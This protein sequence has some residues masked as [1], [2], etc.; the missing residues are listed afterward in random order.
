MKSKIITQSNFLVVLIFGLFAV[1]FYFFSFIGSDYSPYYGDEF[2]Y[3]KNAESFYQFSEFHGAFT[4]SGKGSKLLGFDPHGPAYPILYGSVAKLIGWHGPLIPIFN[5]GILIIALFCLFLQK[6]QSLELKYIQVILILGSPVTLF[7]SFSFLPELL[8]IAGAIFLFL[9]FKQYYRTQK[10]FDLILLTLL[11]LSLGMIRTIWFFALIALMISPKG[12]NWRVG[13]GL[14][15]LALSLSYFSQALF[16]EPVP[17]TF[18]ELSELVR[19]KNY[20]EA[21]EV[22][23]F[24]LKRN[25]YF[26][27]TYSEGKFYTI[28]KIWLLASIAF[29]WVFFRK[30]KL[31]Q[32]GLLIF[33]MTY[34]FNMF[35]YK[36]YSWV[37]LRM[38]TPILL[39]I[40]LSMIASSNHKFISK[41]LVVMGLSS[42]VLIIPLSKKLISYRI[43]SDLKNIPEST[44]EALLDLN[45]PLILI[46]KQA[47]Q[48]YS[49]DQLPISTR[50]KKTIRYILPFYEV[51]IEQPTHKITEEK[52][53]LKVSPVKILSQ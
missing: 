26:V 15:L 53:Q 52:G 8:Q 35:F 24:N 50:E 11:I 33:G 51:E 19:S 12:I 1:Y 25:L 42:F 10:Q 17:N 3:F 38:Y 49:L 37:D 5:C 36:N 18:S 48:E 41:S 29:A 16:H 23:I 31:V 9:Q 20:G 47:L 32:V 7:Y 28:Q 40:N 4:Y 27:G 2:F 6:G 30:E 22:L 44:K 46:S 39:F 45:Q 21:V 43:I 34:L 13:L 14:L